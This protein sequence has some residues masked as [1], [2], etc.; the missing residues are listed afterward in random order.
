MGQKSVY[1]LSTADGEPI[2][3][4]SMS[5]NLPNKGNCFP[6][7]IAF[8]GHPCYTGG[9]FFSHKWLF[10]QQ[11]SLLS[12]ASRPAGSQGSCSTISDVLFPKLPEQ[13]YTEY[14]CEYKGMAIY[15]FVYENYRDA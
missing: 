6:N 12:G 10:S 13:V 7:R 11:A 1:R 2:R 14:E 5:A 9:Y 8:I 4:T 15:N 3:G